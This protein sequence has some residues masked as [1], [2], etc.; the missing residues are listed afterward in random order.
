MNLES[1]MIWKVQ[2]LLKNGPFPPSTPKF[3]E[4]SVYHRIYL[5][6]HEALK[7]YFSNGAL[8]SS[9]LPVPILDEEE[10]IKL[11]LFSHFFVVPQKVLWRLYVS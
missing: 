11:N 1:N 7:Y 6:C 9:T 3:N 4:V 5:Q 10:K 8:L 2:L